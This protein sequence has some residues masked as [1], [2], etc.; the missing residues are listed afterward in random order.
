MNKDMIIKRENEDI[1]FLREHD[2]NTP[3]CIK[4]KD[5]TSH[6]PSKH[7]YYLKLEPDKFEVYNGSVYAD[8]PAK[9]VGIKTSVEIIKE[10]W[11]D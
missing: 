4:S 10:W 6:G 3:I 8:E 2:G 9:L 7:G 1:E 5:Y 11:I